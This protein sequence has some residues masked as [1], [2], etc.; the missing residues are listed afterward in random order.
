MPS[1]TAPTAH[2]YARSA[3]RD[4][5]VETVKGALRHQFP[6]WRIIATDRGRWVG[7]R[8]PLPTDEHGR[9]LDT[10]QTSAVEACTPYELQQRL[11]GA[12][13]PHDPDGGL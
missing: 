3:A 12:D 10:G 13:H 2:H 6:G 8:D 5:V 9:V 1:P 4:D 11:A 7:V